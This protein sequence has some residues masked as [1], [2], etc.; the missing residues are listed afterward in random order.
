MMNQPLGYLGERPLDQQ[1]T[2]PQDVNPLGK[3]S[4]KNKVEYLGENPKEKP[5]EKPESSLDKYKNKKSYEIKTG[6]G[7]LKK[8]Q[9]EDVTG[10]RPE[11]PKRDSYEDYLKELR[12]K[13]AQADEMQEQW[14]KEDTSDLWKGLAEGIT[15]GGVEYDE[16]PTS[17]VARL[18]GKVIGSLPYVI[19]SFGL[20]KFGLTRLMPTIMAGGKG[21]GWLHNITSAV[22]PRLATTTTAATG[23]AASKE[24]V[25][26]ATGKDVNWEAIPEEAINWA[27]FDLALGGILVGAPAAYRRIKN[28]SKKD[29]ESIFVKGVIPENLSARDYE[30]T[31]NAITEIRTKGREDLQ[32]ST[33]KAQEDLDLQ[34]SQKM[35]NVKAEYEK[36]EYERG[37]L[38]QEY[39]TKSAELEAENKAALEEWDRQSREWDQSVKRQ[40]SVQNALQL[41]KNQRQGGGSLQGRV[42]EGGQ[43][44]GIRSPTLPPPTRIQN[45]VGNI[46]SPRRIS[47]PT[48]AGERNVAGV[49][50]SDVVDRQ[51]VNDAYTTSRQANEGLILP[52]EELANEI[53]AGLEELNSWG[54]N[55]PPAVENIRTKLQSGLNELIEFNEAG[56]AIGYRPVSNQYLLD[57]AKALR[58]DMQYGFQHG[59][60]YNINRPYVEAYQDAV[61]RTAE[62]LGNT[63]AATANRVARTKYR[64]WAEL[65]NNPYIRRY[66]N[67]IVN[68][69]TTLFESSLSIDNYRTLDNVLSRSRDGAIL[70]NETRRALVDNELKGF[71]KDPQKVSIEKLNETLNDLRPI[72]N[73]GEEDAIRRVFIE[74]KSSMKARGRKVSGEEKPEAP[75]AKTATKP[76]EG[77]TSVDIPNKPNL[78]DTPEMKEARKRADITEDQLQRYLKSKNGFDKIK[79]MMG[80]GKANEQIYNELVKH[81]ARDILYGGKMRPNFKGTELSD[82]LNVRK[83]R[84]LME[85]LFSKEI[86]EEIDKAAIEIGQENVTKESLK[87]LVKGTTAIKFINTFFPL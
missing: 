84:E 18:T 51:A 55:A 44:L 49:R 14:Q 79:E 46:I 54:A 40:E 43:P 21:A 22:A 27:A 3:Y 65:Y 11:Q 63:E 47:N 69:P 61:E 62:A 71:Y 70:S 37:R 10:V 48:E 74:N 66:R 17:P 9:E 6:G 83:D 82:R 87:R 31:E 36:G 72:L 35:A 24:G 76:P 12:G 39:E 8:D 81:K 60:S 50:A 68:Q 5:E 58:D 42:T 20:A 52:Q 25:R 56:E 23:F 78:K 16:P 85:Q 45:E 57:K 86:V 7:E 15:H 73:P 2:P 4:R 28:F 41:V 26:A 34:Y 19:G 64:E 29:K 33:Q 32:R 75:K 80:P 53:R 38:Q 13:L 30:A 77:P 59:D 67:R 1:P